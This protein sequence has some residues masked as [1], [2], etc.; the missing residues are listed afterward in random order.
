MHV[1]IYLGAILLMNL[2]AVF[3][4]FSCSVP[5]QIENYF[6]EHQQTR[7]IEL[8]FMAHS[9][10]ELATPL[11][12][13]HF[14]TYQVVWVWHICQKRCLILYKVAPTQR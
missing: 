12:G 6:K 8:T 14:G 11:K 2:A 1:V 10:T 9:S 7:L 4:D 13:P 3:S 5:V